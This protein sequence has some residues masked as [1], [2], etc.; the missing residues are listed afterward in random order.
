MDYR[1]LPAAAPK[2]IALAAPDTKIYQF[3]GGAAS[4]FGT[5]ILGVLIT[6]FTLFTPGICYPFA[7]V[8]VEG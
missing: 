1:K 3:R 5:Q 4:W 7:I 8:L 6:L 2:G